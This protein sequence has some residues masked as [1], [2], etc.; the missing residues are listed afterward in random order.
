MFIQITLTELELTEAVA[1]WLRDTYTVKNVTYNVM[2]GD[3][4]GDSDYVS[5]TA[6]VEIVR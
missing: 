3:R 2:K 5:A 1:H 6:S 4:P